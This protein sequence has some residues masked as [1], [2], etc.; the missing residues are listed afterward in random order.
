MA[1]TRIIAPWVWNFPAMVWPCDCVWRLLAEMS[2]WREVSAADG[3]ALLIIPLTSS[4]V[5]CPQLQLVLAERSSSKIDWWIEDVLL[6]MCRK[7]TEGGTDLTGLSPA[8]HCRAV[9]H[10]LRSTG[11]RRSVQE[12]A[13]EILQTDQLGRL[14]H[15][16]IP[17]FSVTFNDIV[18]F[19]HWLLWDSEWVTSL[20]GLVFRSVQ[21]LIWPPSFGLSPKFG[22]AER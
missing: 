5:A 4:H 13:A 12:E 15:I 1:F 20:F 21:R 16:Y 7:S 18:S 6:S 22:L 17:L 9:W 3:E 10:V 8:E 14:G 2:M 19:C 11:P